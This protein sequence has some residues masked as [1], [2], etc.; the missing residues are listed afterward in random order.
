M[1][2]SMPMITTND[3]A[4]LYYEDRGRGR[5]IVFVNGWCMTTRFWHRQV[6]GLSSDFRCIT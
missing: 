2:Q 6:D 4:G 3:G 5:P 1:V